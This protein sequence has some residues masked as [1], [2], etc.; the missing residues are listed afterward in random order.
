MIY[1]VMSS[2]IPQKSVHKSYLAAVHSVI[3]AINGYYELSLFNQLVFVLNDQF[4]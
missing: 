4:D 2:L 1:I 3:M